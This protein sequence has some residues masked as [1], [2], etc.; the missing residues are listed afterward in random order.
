MDLL[1]LEV[2]KVLAGQRVLLVP[3]ALADP[4]DR[5][6]QPV[7]MELSDHPDLSVRSDHGV[8]KGP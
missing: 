3:E 6:G 4:W 1:A 2:Q 5:S 7:L 8:L